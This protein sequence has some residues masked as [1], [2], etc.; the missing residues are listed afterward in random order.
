MKVKMKI[1]HLFFIIIGGLLFISTI[2]YVIAPQINYFFTIKQLDNNK[3]KAGENLLALLDSPLPKQQKW[4]LIENYMLYDGLDNQ[5]DVYTGPSITYYHDISLTW[6]EKLPFIDQYVK[7]G[8]LDDTLSF[9]VERLADYYL[10]DTEKVDA[11]FATALARIPKNDPWLHNEL[12]LS[13][14]KVSLKQGLFQKAEQ[15]LH[16]MEANA[17]PDDDTLAAINVFQAEILI[18]EGKLAEAKEQIKL[19]KA[20]FK[21]NWF[22]FNEEE[23]SDLMKEQ[24]L[25]EKMMLLEQR[26]TERTYKKQH[27]EGKITGKITRN[28]GTP[29]ANIAVFLKE[30][31]QVYRSRSEFQRYETRTNE[32][33]EYEFNYVMPGSYQ[34]FL[35]MMYDQIDGWT[36]PNERNDWIDIDGTKEVTYDVTFHPLIDIDTPTNYQTI[37]T[38]HILFSWEEVEEAAYYNIQLGV[39]MEEVSTTI[40]F[41]THIKGNELSVPIEDMYAQTVGVSFHDDEDPFQSVNPSS[42]LAFTNPDGKYFW[43]VEAYTKDDELLTRSDGYRLH[44]DTVGKLPF[45]YLKERTLSDADKLLVQK[46]VKGALQA[47]KEAYENNPDDL[48]SLRMITRLVR[49]EVEAKETDIEKTNHALPYYLDLAEKNA[50]STEDLLTILSFYYDI[51]DFTSFHTWLKVYER[52]VGGKENLDVYVRS[53]YASALMKQGQLKEAQKVF[54]KVVPDD[55]DHRFIGHWLATEI[56]LDESFDT[57]LTLADHYPERDLESERLS[58]FMLM[59]ALEKEAKQDDHYRKEMKETI[60]LFFQQEEETLKEWEVTTNKHALKKF[61]QALQSVS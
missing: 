25:Y 11:I 54:Q 48:H 51:Q 49:H 52:E 55:K 17:S 34:L 14:V 36:W 59:M 1:K 28:D 35:G 47:Y 37:T 45:F 26:I 50:A 43:S 12:M 8:P 61:M 30:E 38:D 60:L 21:T 13:Q 3:P 33:G 23:E 19:G 40:E 15:L 6:E 44:E 31:E 9:A 27:Y 58:W 29:I 41:K 56:L 22:S 4:N 24:P 7:E 20:A 10:H 16:E 57:L 53:L 42:I 39:A 18:H 5:F 32:H 46:D 2:H